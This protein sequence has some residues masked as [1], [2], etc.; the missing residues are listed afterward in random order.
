VGPSAGGR[1]VAGVLGLCVVQG[2][3][4]SPNGGVVPVLR[5][6]ARSIGPASVSRGV[7]SRLDRVVVVASAAGAER[8]PRGGGLSPGGPPGATGA[9][10]EARFLLAE[11][12]RPGLIGHCTQCIHWATRNATLR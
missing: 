2:P 8:E 5:S 7:A 1:G 10:S 9:L 12:Y 4:V 11:V 3:W 6:A